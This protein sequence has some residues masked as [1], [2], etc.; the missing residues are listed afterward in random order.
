MNYILNFIFFNIT[1]NITFWIIK[2]IIKYYFQN[3]LKIPIKV[4]IHILYT[5]GICI[6]A[7]IIIFAVADLFKVETIIQIIFSAAL[8]IIFTKDVW[9]MSSQIMKKYKD[10]YFYIFSKQDP[11]S[12]RKNLSKNLTNINEFQKGTISQV[13]RFMNPYPYQLFINPSKTINACSYLDENKIVITKG[14]LSLPLDEIKAA[15][16][17]EIMHFEVD[18]LDSDKKKKKRLFV[19]LYLIYLA[20]FIVSMIA[21]MISKYLLLLIV[22][23]LAGYIF[24]FI[25]CH[26]VIAER[27]LYQMSEL[28]CDR[29][30]CQLPGVTKEGMIKLLT[31][32]EKAQNHN[33]KKY[34]WYLEII[35]RYFLFEDHP[36]I[37]YRIKRIKKY[38]NWNILEFIKVPLHMCFRLITGKGWN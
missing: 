12:I 20:F 28:K 36:N 30:A 15:L 32:L 23:F 6:F 26:V 24:V 14:L 29:L 2:D 10:S 22:I 1:Y 11:Y 35:R 37:K 7:P 38:C 16:G 27:Y 4:Y 25:F 5:V 21:S 9:F 33:I 34:P 3:K 19:T 8:G 31:R 17:H 13:I 18:G